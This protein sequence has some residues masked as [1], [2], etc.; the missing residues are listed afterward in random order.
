MRDHEKTIYNVIGCLLIIP[1]FIAG[2]NLLKLWVNPG[3]TESYYRDGMV[4]IK[5]FYYALIFV[6]VFMTWVVFR[7][8]I[9][10]LKHQEE[11]EIQLGVKE[12]EYTKKINDLEK[13][14]Q[15][16]L[17]FQLMINSQMS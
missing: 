10:M 2:V 7:M 8:R 15:K 5:L 12:R 4:S 9:I 3:D 1:F 13:N 17:N 6:I 16:R 14:Y 11:Y